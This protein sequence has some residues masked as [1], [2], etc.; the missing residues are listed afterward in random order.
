MAGG[1]GFFK[2]TSPIVPCEGERDTKDGICKMEQNGAGVGMFTNQDLKAPYTAPY[3]GADTG[4]VR[5]NGG[6]HDGIKRRGGSYLRGFPGDMVNTLFI[7][8]RRWQPEARWCPPSIW[9]RGE[10]TRPASQDFDNCMY[11]A[12]Y[13]GAL[14]PVSPGGAASALRLCFWGCDGQCP[15]LPDHLHCPTPWPCIIPAPPCS[16]PWEIPGYP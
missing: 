12:Y 3:C 8:L 14:H 2:K 7:V 13:N 5:W 4:C 11:F 6:Y 9:D 10:G 16:A 15:G 1:V